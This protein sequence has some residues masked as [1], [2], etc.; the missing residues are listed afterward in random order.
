MTNPI[1]DIE[2][3]DVILVAGSNTTETHPVISSAIKRAVKFGG[4]KLIVADPRRIEL[5]KH[6][7]LSLSPNPGSDIAWINGMIRVILEE[8]LEDAAYIKERTEGIDALREAV[9]PYTPEHV[10]ELTGIPAEQLIQAALVYAG[11]EKGSILY[12]M[13]ITQHTTGTDN[14]KA[15]A[16]LSMVC[17]NVGIEGGGVNPLRGQNNVQ[18]ACDMGGLPDVYPGY[19]KVHEEPHALS[20][21]KAWG[22]SGLSRTPGLTATEMVDAAIKGSLKALYVIGENPLVSE[23]D[24]NHA[25]KAFHNLDFLVVQDIFLTETAQA[26]DVVLPALCFAEKDGTF[27]NTERRVQRVRNAV[28]GPEGVPT[29]WEVTC[30]VA[31]RMGVDMSYASAEAIFD[32]LASVTPAFGGLSYERLDGE[33]IPW[34]CPTADHPGTPRLHVESFAKGKGTFFPVAFTPAAETPDADY[35]LVLTTGRVLYHYH[36]GTMT[37]KSDGLNQQ[38]GECFVEMNRED[39]REKNLAH[40]DMATLFSRRGKIKAR[41]NISGRMEQGT[42][43]LPFHFA[44]AA[45]NRLT[46]AKLD[47]VSKIPEFKVCA[48]TVEKA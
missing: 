37:R 8:R 32:E 1:S 3:A 10:E 40:G 5:K 38:V 46:N 21:E 36:T 41:V 39:A 44:E 28:E 17:G 20:M 12:C 13:G 29:D 47:P 14:V 23:A 45:A 24:L 35:P 30:E 16:N 19:R 2:K 11:V 7:H 9:A 22:V 48:V 34:P 25:E 27:T 42:V 4:T 43:F 6:A 15:L 26:A 18:G 33:G 31:R